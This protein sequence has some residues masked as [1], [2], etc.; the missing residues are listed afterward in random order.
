MNVWKSAEHYAEDCTLWHFLSF[1]ICVR[2]ICEMFVCLQTSRKTE[3]V[4]N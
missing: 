4:K 3:Y 2:E 1:E